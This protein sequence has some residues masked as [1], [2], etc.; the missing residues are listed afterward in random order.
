VIETDRPA[1]PIIPPHC[2]SEGGVNKALGELDE[3]TRNRKVGGHLTEGKLG[4]KISL[5]GL[6]DRGM[7]HHGS[8]AYRANE[9]VTKEKTNRTSILEG[10]GSA[11]E[12]PSADD[13]TDT[14][15]V[16]CVVQQ[17]DGVVRTLS[18]RHDDSLACD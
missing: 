2:K 10:S 18:W 13:T 6:V 16:G 14:A 17:S 11:K 15:R 12:K 5:Y 9:D 7:D 8:V 3:T 1:V 4:R